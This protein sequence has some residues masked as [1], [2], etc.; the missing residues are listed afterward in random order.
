MG[1][2][3]GENSLLRFRFPVRACLDSGNKFGRARFIGVF[4]LVWDQVKFLELEVAL[5]RANEVDLD[6]AIGQF[7]PENVVEGNRPR[8]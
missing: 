2:D 7:G 4:G 5:R 3:E 8:R 6:G 1:V